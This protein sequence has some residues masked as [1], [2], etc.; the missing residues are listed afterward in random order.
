MTVNTQFQGFTGRNADA[1]P[2]Q[3]GDQSSAAFQG[4]AMPNPRYLPAL[5]AIALFASAASAQT[6]TP[7]VSFSSGLDYSQGKYGADTKTEIIYLPFTARLAAGD[8]NISAT[9]PF[10][11][12]SG[13]GD[14][15][16][17][18]T[19]GPIVIRRRGRT[20][21][22]PGSVTPPVTTR[23][24]VSG[25]GDASIAAGYSLPESLSPAWLV[26]FQGRV[27]IPTASLSKGLGTGKADFGIA[28]EVSRQLGAVTPFVN[29]GYRVLGDPAGIDLRNGV[30]ASAGF[31]VDGSAGTFLASYDYSAK[32]VATSTDSHSLF[33]SYSSR[34]S[35]RLLLTGYG[36]AGLTS[37]APDFALGL[38]LG[39]DV[40]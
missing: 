33:A 6:I 5:S 19:T 15:V 1:R 12:I 20:I 40:N 34:I 21:T 37:S 8:F 35:G 39:W 11:R 32:S 30:T 24:S 31:S 16:A 13:A 9:L 25:L 22:I 10:T 27:K 3:E 29:F 2:L 14:V 36:L 38:Q 23:T 26:E 4:P 7:K 28:L 18:G 17:G